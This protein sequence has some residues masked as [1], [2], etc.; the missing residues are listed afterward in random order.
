MSETISEYRYLLPDP[1]RVCRLKSNYKQLTYFLHVFLKFSHKTEDV[2][3]IGF[4]FN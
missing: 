2:I 1:V 4:S 3:L